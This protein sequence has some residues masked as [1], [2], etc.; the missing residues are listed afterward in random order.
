MPRFMVTRSLPPLTDA[1]VRVVAQNV[2]KACEQIEGMSWIRSH[3]TADGK[4]SFCEMEAPDAEAVR[5]HAS[6]AGLPLDDVAAVP[7][8]IGPSML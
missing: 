2:V 8:E 5:R 4:H 6:L 3:I 1:E 7:R